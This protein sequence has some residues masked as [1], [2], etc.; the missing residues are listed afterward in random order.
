M[1][2]TDPNYP[3]TGDPHY[4]QYMKPAYTSAP[5]DPT[6]PNPAG[7]AAM[8]NAVSLSS[9]APT[10]GPHTSRVV[11]NATSKCLD[12]DVGGG[13]AQIWDC[14]TGSNQLWTLNVDGT[15][16]TGGVCLQMPAG[17]TANHTPVSVATCN[18]ADNQRW[19]VGTGNTLLNVQSGRCLD[20]DSGDYTNGRQLQIYDCVGGPNQTWRWS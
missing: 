7:L 10:S 16:T 1:A 9:L 8:A 5:G 11:W 13:H 20:L 18:G 15:V 4:D 6:H 19:A 3:T 2:N 14:L 17:V 12:R